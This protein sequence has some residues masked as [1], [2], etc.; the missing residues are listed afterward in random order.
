MTL[1]RPRVNGYTV[2]AR[3]ETNFGV[4]RYARILGIPR[5]AN[6]GNFIEINAKGCFSH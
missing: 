2:S 5:I 1:V 4:M 3:F 6:Q